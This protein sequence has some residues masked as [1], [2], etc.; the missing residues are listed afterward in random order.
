MEATDSRAPARPRRGRYGRCSSPLPT[1]PAWNSNRRNLSGRITPAAITGSQR[2][3][4]S[5][6][7]RPTMAP[8]PCCLRAEN[9]ELPHLVASCTD[10]ARN[11]PRVV[12]SC[13][14]GQLKHW[15]QIMGS[16]DY[17]RPIPQKLIAHERDGIAFFVTIHPT[18]PD[19][20]PV[21]DDYFREIGRF[22]HDHHVARFLPTHRS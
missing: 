21:T 18:H 6:M 13:G 11:R 2:L 4:L 14:D 20:R 3:E 7:V 1:L 19:L 15:R 22:F 8:E 10:S 5:D 16:G 12:I 9:L 17:P